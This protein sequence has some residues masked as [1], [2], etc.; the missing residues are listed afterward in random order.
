[1]MAFSRSFAS[2]SSIV[3][4]AT[5]LH[6]RHAN[7]SQVQTKSATNRV[8]PN[9]F[10]SGPPS[11]VG[12]RASAI[13]KL[14]LGSLRPRNAARNCRITSAGVMSRLLALLAVCAVAFL[15]TPQPITIPQTEPPTEVAASEP[16]NFPFP[17][18]GDLETEP[19]DPFH[20]V[21][22]LPELDRAEKVAADA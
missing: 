8:L 10:V 4:S 1:S 5:R 15:C 3:V 16:E 7:R 22:T 9:R 2:S 18:G 11:R 13:R 19:P 6:V 17:D 14:I 20:Q 12:T 21:G